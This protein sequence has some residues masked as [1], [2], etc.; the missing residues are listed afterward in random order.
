MEKT[1]PIDTHEPPILLYD[2]RCSLCTSLAGFVHK[3]TKG[4]ILIKSWQEFSQSKNHAFQHLKNQEADK[5][6]IFKDNSILE[7]RAAWKYLLNTYSDLASISWIAKRLG[8][9]EQTSA[10][11]EKGGH[12]LRRLWCRNCRGRL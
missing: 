2:G 11:L 8:I 10:F 1:K 12:T 3:R 9:E 7:G 6:R 5:L 4:E